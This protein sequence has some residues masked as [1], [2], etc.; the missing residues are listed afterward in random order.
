MPARTGITPT[1]KGNQ[2]MSTMS[3]AGIVATTPRHVTTAEGLAIT[4]F[5]LASNRRRFDTRENKWVDLDTNWFTVVAF[6][7]L[8]QNTHDSIHKGDR[9]VVA[10]RVRVREWENDSSTGTA[11]E[12]EAESLGHDLLW[13]TTEYTK[14]TRLVE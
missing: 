3:T 4:S 12:I 13:G 1:H 7:Q 8:A 2:K 14:N 9:V 11:V 6:R 10:G 5:R